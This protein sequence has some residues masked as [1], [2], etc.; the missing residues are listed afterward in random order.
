M[1]INL[2]E[3][4][5]DGKSWLLNE[6]TAELSA[7]LKDLIG[8]Q[9]YQTEFTITPLP[10]PGA[11]ELRGKI[12]TKVPE[13]CSRCGIDFNYTINEKFYYILM[14]EIDLP[15]D[16]KFAKPNHYT[17]L[18]EDKTETAEYQGHH[19]NVSE[20]FHELVAVNI[21]IIP[22]PPVDENEDCGECKI[23]LKNHS[24]SMDEGEVKPKNP[25]S[26]LKGIKLN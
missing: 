26:A 5:T 24:F 19:F 17:D 4:P 21:P 13:L 18:H 14:P 22:A 10:S 1:K 16:G 20:F 3:I 8:A 9:P 6:K 23:S 7:S 25:F 12:S 2:N 11:Y 15:R